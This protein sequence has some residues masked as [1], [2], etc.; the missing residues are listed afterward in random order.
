MIVLLPQKNKT[1]TKQAK[2]KTQTTTKPKQTKAQNKTKPPNCSRVR[3]IEAFEFLL[4]KK[5]VY[6]H[7]RL[8]KRCTLDQV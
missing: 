5:P 3:F 7:V 4:S 2:Q 8:Y 1:K 6:M